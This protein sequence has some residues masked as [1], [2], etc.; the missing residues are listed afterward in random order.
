[1]LGNERQAKGGLWK[2]TCRLKEN[3]GKGAE[4]EGATRERVQGLADRAPAESADARGVD[5]L[6]AQI[7]VAH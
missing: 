7:P 1:M 4:R 3:E 2:Q 6:N 5:G